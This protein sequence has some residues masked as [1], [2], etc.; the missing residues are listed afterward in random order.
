MILISLGERKQGKHSNQSVFVCQT[1]PANQCLLCRNTHFQSTEKLSWEVGSEKRGWLVPRITARGQALEPC[2][3][4]NRAVQALQTMSVCRN[5]ATFSTCAA[6]SLRIL[7]VLAWPVQ[8]QLGSENKVMDN[9]TVRQGETVLLR[10]VLIMSSWQIRFVLMDPAWA[11]I[12]S[13][14]QKQNG[15]SWRETGEIYRSAVARLQK[16]KI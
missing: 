3:Q 5:L 11:S 10:S 16:G 6:L 7:F 9:I 13:K 12:G 1:Q 2:V 15:V 8:S 4:T 14:Q